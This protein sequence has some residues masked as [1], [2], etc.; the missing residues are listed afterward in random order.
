MQQHKQQPGIAELL[1]MPD[2]ATIDFEPPRLA[3]NLFNPA[4][5]S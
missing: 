5:L 1:A 3:S 4:D 2:A